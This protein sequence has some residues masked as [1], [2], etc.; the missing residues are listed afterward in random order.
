MMRMFLCL[1][2]NFDCIRIGTSGIA[3]VKPEDGGGLAELQLISTESPL[4]LDYNDT[5]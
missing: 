3:Y 4:D 2:V 5:A 1:K